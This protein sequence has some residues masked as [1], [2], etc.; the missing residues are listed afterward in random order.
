MEAGRSL[1]ASTAGSRLDGHG[2]AFIQDS[3]SCTARSCPLALAGGHLEWRVALPVVGSLFGKSHTD[4]GAPYFR[5]G[6]TGL[7]GALRHGA[8]E[9]E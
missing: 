7:T 1:D 9:S 3:L 8:C 5:P 4:V 6:D 2:H